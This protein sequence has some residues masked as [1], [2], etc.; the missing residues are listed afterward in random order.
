MDGH[1]VVTICRQFGAEGHEIGKI[2]SDRLG[3][4]LYDKDI[5]G[6]AA[7][8]AGVEK[9]HF[10]RADEQVVSRFFEPYLLLSMG[11]VTRNDR[12]FE[13]EE[14]I[15]RD[16][17]AAGSC[18]IVGRLSDYLLR[19]DP[20]TI[21]VFVFAS[22][23]FRVENI[24]KKYEI[25]ETAAKKLVRQMDEMRRSYY[26]CYSGGNWRQDTGKDLTL[27]RE[28]FGIGGC[29]DILEAAVRVKFA[30]QKGEC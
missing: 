28:T 14:Q 12:L 4:A 9:G 20:N 1:V 11:T 5:L 24:R 29:T 2:L 18:V 23:N 15:I 6:K 7:E 25:S 30:A 21:K 13:A 8:S 17:A 19:K 10:R 26:A 3:M 16:V 22:M 27:D